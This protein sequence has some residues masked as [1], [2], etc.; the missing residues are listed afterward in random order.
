MLGLVGEPRETFPSDYTTLGA[1]I[2]WSRAGHSSASYT[3]NCAHTY[4]SIAYST[5]AKPAI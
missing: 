3:R 1:F 2:L 5:Y 4:A